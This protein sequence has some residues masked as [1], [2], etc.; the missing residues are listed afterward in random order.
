MTEHL[1][2]AFA[3]ADLFNIQLH[4]IAARRATRSS[5]ASVSWIAILG[6]EIFLYPHYQ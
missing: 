2:L 5:I 3:F 6:G 1:R 4:R